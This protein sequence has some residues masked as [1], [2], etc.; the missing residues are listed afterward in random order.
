M[1]HIMLTRFF[2]EM[3]LYHVVNHLPPRAVQ[4]VTS[5]TDAG[6]SQTALRQKLWQLLKAI[7]DDVSLVLRI[8]FPKVR[9]EIRG[10]YN[11]ES[12]ITKSGSIKLNA[13]WL[14][15]FPWYR[16][17]RFRT[18]LTIRTGGFQ[19]PPPLFPGQYRINPWVICIT[20]GCVIRI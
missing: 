16:P 7:C 6:I 11:K 14:E 2:Y 8:D 20:T 12:W 19:Q 3:G 9:P 5:C 4:M 10:I 13:L 15:S 17:Y 1:I 18:Y